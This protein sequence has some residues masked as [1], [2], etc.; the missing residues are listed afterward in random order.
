MNNFQKLES[1]KNTLEATITKYNKYE[2]EQVNKNKIL[3]D[4]NKLLKEAS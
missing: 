3:S 1:F 4:L 2:G